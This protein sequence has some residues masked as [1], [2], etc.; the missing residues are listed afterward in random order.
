MKKEFHLSSSLFLLFYL[1]LQDNLRDVLLN[2]RLRVRA[3]FNCAQV[4]LQNLRVGAI[5]VN[6]VDPRLRISPVCHD[7]LVH[8]VVG[9]QSGVNVGPDVRELLATSDIRQHQPA[10]LAISHVDSCN[11]ADL[12]ADRCNVVVIRSRNELR[13]NQSPA[14]HDRV[15]VERHL[16]EI[17]FS[18]ARVAHQHGEELP[19]ARN[20]RCLHPFCDMC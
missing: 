15:V 10:D 17:G 8:H 14:I 11:G 4:Q 18:D 16:R 3:C 12:G 2:P 13:A 20:C 6:L 19:V 9:H 5:C 7:E 1:I